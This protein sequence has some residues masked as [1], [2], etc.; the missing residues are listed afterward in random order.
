VT[1]EKKGRTPMGR[2]EE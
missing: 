1:I 2:K